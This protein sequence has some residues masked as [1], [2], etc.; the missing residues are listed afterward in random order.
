MLFMGSKKFPDEN[1]YDSFLA[2]HG[3]ASNAYT[4]MV[5]RL[6]ASACLDKAAQISMHGPVSGAHQSV[7]APFR[8]VLKTSFLLVKIDRTAG[9]HILSF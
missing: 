8:M 3:G 5:S 4:E 9:I 6:R 1:E 2:K 7:A